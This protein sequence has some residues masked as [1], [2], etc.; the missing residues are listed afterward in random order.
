[1]AR[2]MFARSLCVPASAL[3]TES[4]TVIGVYPPLPSPLS[5][6]RTS[7]SGIEK[8]GTVLS[9]LNLQV[10]FNGPLVTL[11]VI[12]HLSVDSVLQFNALVTLIPF[13]LFARTLISFR[14][15]L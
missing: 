1:M 6:F 12:D 7:A 9:L 5:S 10:Y 2:N 13:E 3:P 14:T 11:S 15:Y 8:S 4:H